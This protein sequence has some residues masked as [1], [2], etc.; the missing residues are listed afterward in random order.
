MLTDEYFSPITKLRLDN[1]FNRS[2]NRRTLY[3]PLQVDVSGRGKGRVN[4]IEANR[5]VKNYA[6]KT[7]CLRL[8]DRN[9]TRVSRS[10]QFIKN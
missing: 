4:Y 10:V 6:L 3:S 7:I 2:E 1:L 8:F 9:R 5:D